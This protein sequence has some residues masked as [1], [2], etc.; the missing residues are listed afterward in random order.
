MSFEMAK[1]DTLDW[2]DIENQLCSLFSAKEKLS[3]CSDTTN[4][5]LIHSREMWA[6]V[7]RMHKVSNYVQPYASLWFNPT[8]R[9]GK[10]PAYW[11]QWHLS[12]RTIGDPYKNEQFVSLEELR[13]HFKLKGKQHFWRYLQIRNCLKSLS[14]CNS[15]DNYIMDYMHM[16]L[17]RCTAS[18][19]YKLTNLAVSGGSI[20]VKL[21]WQRDLG[22]NLTQ[23]KWLDILAG[24]GKYV[25]EA[26]G[27]FTQYK[28]LHRKYH[29]PVRLHRMKLLKD[30]EFWKCKTR[31]VTFLH[32]M[33]ECTLVAQFWV[34]VVDFL[35]GWSGLTIPLSPFMCL[36]GDR[37]QLP[38]KSQK[39]IL[40]YYGGS[41]DCLQSTVK[42]V[43]NKCNP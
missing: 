5:V 31:V 19:F 37:F 28:I 36:L 39:Y 6:R 38:N 16:P 29:T 43:E 41:D 26:R 34:E 13:C 24:C 27:K 35:S 32:C 1:F 11:K 12:V 30:N 14:G 33:W 20:N 42:K 2:M 40:C 9:V 10:V 7:H 21:L 17:E 18:Q 3:Q 22:T 8:I 15:S 4:P 25:R 23:D